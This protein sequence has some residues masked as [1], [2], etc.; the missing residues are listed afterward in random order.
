MKDITGQKFGKLCALAFHHRYNTKAF[1]TFKCDC[2]DTVIAQGYQ[3]TSGKTKSC[4][5]LKKKL[6]FENLSGK[7]FGRYTVVEESGYDEHGFLKLLCLCDCGTKK[8]VL[9]QSLRSER[10]KSCG[11]LKKQKAKETA[12]TR[13][14]KHGLT[15]R[16]QIHPLFRKW[17][18]MMN[19][20]YRIN[21]DSWKNYGGRGIK[22][23][24]QWHTFLNFYNDMIASY[25]GHSQ[26]HG[27]RFTTIDRINNNGNYSPD[28]CRWATPKEQANN[29]RM[30]SDSRLTSP[31][32][33][34]V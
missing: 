6:F 28:N 30:R 25:T 2:G 22:V 34:R 32:K 19:R 15:R 3:V 8:I 29:R 23:C 13:F 10:T 11:C 20:C 31:N 18:G 9:Y 33:S 14:V 5:C 1:W 24:K 17:N 7:K 16:N 26:L 21:E 12:T 4:G 27:Q